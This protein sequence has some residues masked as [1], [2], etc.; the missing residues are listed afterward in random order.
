MRGENDSKQSD[1]FQANLDVVAPKRVVFYNIG[2]ES[3]LVQVVPV[4]K[5]PSLQQY[6][7][8]SMYLMR[9]RVIPRP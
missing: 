5:A 6:I 9:C 7:F 4:K 2:E 8:H 3:Q 1:E